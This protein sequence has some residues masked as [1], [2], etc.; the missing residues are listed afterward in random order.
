MFEIST[1]ESELE[2]RMRTSTIRRLSV[3]HACSD[4]RS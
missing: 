4:R 1:S 3:R 2:S